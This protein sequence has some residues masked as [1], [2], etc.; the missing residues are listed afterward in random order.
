MSKAELNT[1]P[2][3]FDCMSEQEKAKNYA[4]KRRYGITLVD[5][6]RMLDEQDFKCAICGKESGVNGKGMV[7]DHN[8]RTG[9]VR[10][11]LCN[12]CNR[13]V[14]GRIGDDYKR[15][16]G[17]VAYITKQFKEDKLWSEKPVRNVKKKKTSKRLP[18]TRKADSD[19]K[20]TAK[21]AKRKRQRSTTKT[22]KSKQDT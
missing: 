4:L 5:F 14:V 3:L 9:H 13:R 21:S 10:G 1:D 8:H 6:H 2:T 19:T 11:L 12:Y 20:R 17:F 15:M 7:V 18:K 22:R 16:K